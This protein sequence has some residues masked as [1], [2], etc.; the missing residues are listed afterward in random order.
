M[1]C[2]KCGAQISETASFCEHCGTSTNPQHAPAQ[3]SQ[4]Q[5]Q[6][7]VIN[8]VNNNNN[9]NKNI[10]G[11]YVRS[12]KSKIVALILCFM[13][14][15]FGAHRFYVGKSV[16]GL[17]YLFTMGLF[18]IGWFVDIIAIITGGFTDKHGYKLQ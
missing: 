16:S 3:P 6:Q 12:G 18:G 17:L 7:P 5:Y 4:P 13:F 14:G 8:I 10:N 9:V 1:F 15:C 11:G 2:W